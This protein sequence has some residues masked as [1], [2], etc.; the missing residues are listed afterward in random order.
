MEIPCA[1]K[2]EKPKESQRSRQKKEIKKDRKKSSPQSTT[3]WRCRI[4][5]RVQM[6]L[7]FPWNVTRQLWRPRSSV[8]ALREP[9]AASTRWAH[10]CSRARIHARTNAI[11]ML[12]M[13]STF[14]LIQA[15]IRAVSLLPPPPS[16]K[17]FFFSFLCVNTWEPI[18]DILIDFQDFTQLLTYPPSVAY[19]VQYFSIPSNININIPLHSNKIEKSLEEMPQT[20]QN[21]A[22]T[23]CG[24]MWS[25]RQRPTQG[26]SIYTFFVWWKLSFPF[27]GK[28]TNK[29]WI[30][31]R[32][33]YFRKREK[34]ENNRANLFQLKGQRSSLRGALGESD[35]E[36]QRNSQF[37]IRW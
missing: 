26:W 35:K 25:T 2:T 4:I 23:S 7:N 6:R 16:V 14:W 15:M 20:L 18:S 8:C 29:R 24:N 1:P 37:R 17:P 10:L 27:V 12:M 21:R 30:H 9:R 34:L 13:L 5:V 31:K 22:N 33:R 32:C 11:I 3:S 28:W 19:K 36:P